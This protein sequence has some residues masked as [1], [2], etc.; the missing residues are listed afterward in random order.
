MFWRLFVYVG[1]ALVASLH[2]VRNAPKRLLLWWHGGSIYYSV[3]GGRLKSSSIPRN[4]ELCIY[5]YY[6]DGHLRYHFCRGWMFDV[7]ASMQDLHRQAHDSVLVM[8][9]STRVG[10]HQKGSAV[11]SAGAG[12]LCDLTKATC[13]ELASLIDAFLGLRQGTILPKVSVMFDDFSTREF[14]GSDVV[15]VM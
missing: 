15:V 6:C 4:D 10:T 1:L 12:G 9:V 2:V 13:F 8:N 7:D 5:E 14:S 3:R 11:L